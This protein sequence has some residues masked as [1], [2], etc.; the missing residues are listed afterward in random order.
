MARLRGVQLRGDARGLDTA[1]MSTQRF[2]GRTTVLAGRGVRTETAAALGRIG[3]HRPALV[4]DAGLQQNSLVQE[5]RASL[6]A[7]D[8][9][10]V[11][12]LGATSDPTVEQAEMLGAAVAAANADC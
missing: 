3:A 11:T 12:E 9:A 1:G 5:I 6:G 7:T 10:F 2:Y 4:V 8:R